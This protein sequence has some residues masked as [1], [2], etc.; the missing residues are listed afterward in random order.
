MLLF[1]TEL[2]LIIDFLLFQCAGD[3]VNKRSLPRGFLCHVSDFGIENILT[4]ANWIIRELPTTILIY[5]YD[6]LVY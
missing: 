5:I 2:L 4:K 1:V 6:N 3:T